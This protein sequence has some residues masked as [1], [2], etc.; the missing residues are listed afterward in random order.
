[1][2]LT[3][4]IASEIRQLITEKYQVPLELREHTLI[5]LYSPLNTLQNTRN[6]QAGSCPLIHMNCV[7]N[8]SSVQTDPLMDCLFEVKEQIF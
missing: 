3:H 5:C 7:L 1:M 6:P 4:F 8:E 2:N